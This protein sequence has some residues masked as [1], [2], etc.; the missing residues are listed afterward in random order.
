MRARRR[1]PSAASD[2]Y[3]DVPRSILFCD[4]L[5]LIAIPVLRDSPMVKSPAP[6]TNH[7]LASASRGDVSARGRLLE[8]HRQRLM[9]WSPLLLDRRLAS[10]VDPSDVVQET[11]ADAAN[12]WT[13]TF[14][15]GRFRFMPGCDGLRLAGGLTSI[16]VTS[17][18]PAA[19]SIAKNR[20]DCRTSQSWHWRIG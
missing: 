4:V 13:N 20:W 10:R 6:D 2:Y 16:A 15:S 14:A 17:G 7:L 3:E 1:P 8:R 5:L 19:V 11:L 9:R 12:G 18:P